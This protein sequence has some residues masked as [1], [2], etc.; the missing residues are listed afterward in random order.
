MKR[1]LILPLVFMTIALQ[2]QY[3]E[4]GLQLGGTNYVGD[5]SFNS[6]KLYL[7]ETRFG[8][9]LFGRYNF[10]DLFAVKLAA[11]FGNIGGTDA[12]VNIEEIRQR[13]LNFRTP[14]FDFALTGEVNIPGFQPYNL[15]RPISGYLFAGIGA[16]NFQPKGF[17]Q[18]AW[19]NLQPLG[20]EGQGLEGGDGSLYGRWALTIPFGVGFKYA[21]FDKLTLGLEIGARKTFTDYLDD[22]SGNYADIGLLLAER[23]EVAAAL[24]NRTGEYLNSEPLDLTGQAR[25]DQV[26]SDWYFIFGLTVSYNFLDNGLS[27]SRGRNKRRQ[28]CQTF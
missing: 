1:F 8:A 20:T 24:S 18:G 25:G 22:V 14:L 7:K 27:G 17:Y 6:S 13:N 3:F 4:M 9:G 28:G 21:V 26:N 15:N 16:V 11:N 5:L 23:G 2:A 10:S 19:T 12:N